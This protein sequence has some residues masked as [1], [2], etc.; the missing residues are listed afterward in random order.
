MTVLGELHSVALGVSWSDYF[1]YM[2][3]D[4]LEVRV[5]GFLL[6][7]LLLLASVLYTYFSMYVIVMCPF[8]RQSSLDHSTCMSM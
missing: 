5:L 4:L 7:F 3:I 6:F 8:F 2:Y 1:M